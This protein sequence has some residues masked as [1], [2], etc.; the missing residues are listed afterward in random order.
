MTSCE[1]DVTYNIA[2]ITEMGTI[3][4]NYN[5][6]DVNLSDLLKTGCNSYQLQI[7]PL[8]QDIFKLQTGEEMAF[9]TLFPYGKY[10]LYCSTTSQG[11]PM[12]M[13]VGEQTYHIY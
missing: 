2:N 12:K 5:I 7:C 10:G 4:E 6:P 9:P 11:Y 13:S 8:L 1:K 3:E